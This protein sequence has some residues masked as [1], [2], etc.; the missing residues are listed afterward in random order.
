MGFP[1]TKALKNLE[2]LFY[3]HFIHYNKKTGL[4][5]KERKFFPDFKYF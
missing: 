4:V 5:V 3:F 1:H 2:D